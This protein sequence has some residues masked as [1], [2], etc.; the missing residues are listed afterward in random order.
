LHLTRPP[1]L[2]LAARLFIVVV[3]EVA[4]GQVSFS[5]GHKKGGG[6]V[7]PDQHT[8]ATLTRLRTA[9]EMVPPD[10][11]S[12][13]VMLYADGIVEVAFAE[14]AWAGETDVLVVRGAAREW[15]IEAE[16]GTLMRDGPPSSIP[17]VALSRQTGD[18]WAAELVRVGSTE[19]AVLVAPGAVLFGGPFP[20]WGAVTKV[21]SL[22]TAIGWG[23]A[24][25]GRALVLAGP[26]MVWS[27]ARASTKPGPPR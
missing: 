21:W 1:E 20:G 14:P 4:A 25:S 2:I 23:F 10:L 9:P 6:V 26:S 8:E 7:V 27:Y 13:R 11:W 15:V 16:S 5:F 24:P 19:L 22:A 17:T 3:T 18:G 12:P